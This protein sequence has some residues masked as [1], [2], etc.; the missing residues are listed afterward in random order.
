VL[1]AF[2]LRFGLLCYFRTHGPFP[3]SENMPISYETVR[4]ARAIAAGEGFSSPLM[5]DSGPTAW[6]TPLYPLMLA[7]VFRL[8]GILSWT[9]YL[10]I[11]TIDCILSA[12]TAWPIHAL[13]RKAFG[14]GTGIVSG[15]IW[16]VLPSAVTLPIVWVWDTVLAAL[17]FALIFWATL[18]VWP[19]KRPVAW[20]GYGALWGLGMLA[21]PSIVSMFP[22]LLGWMTLQARKGTRQWLQRAAIAIAAFALVFSPWPIRN[23]RV[24]HRVIL[25]RSNLGLELWLGNNSRNPGMWSPWL[26]PSDDREERE[27]LL[28][29]GEIPYM[30]QKRSEALAWMRTHP[31]EV[32][33]DTLH[34]FAG[35]WTGYDEPLVDLAKRPPFALTLFLV[36]TIF[37]L[38]TFSGAL[39][40][41]RRRN[42]CAFPFAA[43]LLFFPL[44]YYFTHASL[45]YRHPID[46]VMTVLSG[47]SV[48]TIFSWLRHPGTEPRPDDAG[49]DPRRELA[50]A[51]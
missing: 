28:R 35:N 29:M 21:N 1:A 49:R 32:A 45:R 4:I 51:G 30:D 6:M 26:H 5:V 36:D 42:P 9:S 7:G 24:F 47:Y 13:G 40:A 46:P 3:I 41:Y 15:W 39:L 38:L 18:A 11:T 22:F 19:S 14:E 44:V 37:P 16:A 10:V 23:Y 50:A 2:L 43:A 27:K 8:F 25:F 31:A 17:L 20:A 33:R 48:V 12:L 34:R